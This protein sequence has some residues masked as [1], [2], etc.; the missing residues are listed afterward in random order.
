MATSAIAALVAAPGRRFT[1]N[2]V[3]CI[4]YDGTY[5]V[6]DVTFIIWDGGSNDLDA[7]QPTRWRPGVPARKVSNP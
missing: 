5:N 7:L 1:V 3:D 2:D 4:M 6:I